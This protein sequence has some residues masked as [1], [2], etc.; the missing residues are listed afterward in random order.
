MADLRTRWVVSR[1]DRDDYEVQTRMRDYGNASRA[2]RVEFGD[3][4]PYTPENAMDYAA[5]MAW[6][7]SVR[8]DLTDEAFSDWYD[9]VVGIEQ[10]PLDVSGPPTS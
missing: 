1:D 6:T 10:V 9:H 5:V 2:F 8:R 3:I 7:V 4:D